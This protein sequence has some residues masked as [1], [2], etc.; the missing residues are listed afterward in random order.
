MWEKNLP[1]RFTYFIVIPLM[2]FGA[3]ERH[4]VLQV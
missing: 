2:H 3:R 1:M 4:G